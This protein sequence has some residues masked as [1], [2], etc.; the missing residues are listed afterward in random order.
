VLSF[1]AFP[2]YRAALGVEFFLPNVNALMLMH[3]HYVNWDLD[4]RSKRALDGVILDP[5]ILQKLESPNSGIGVP[6]VL[7]MVERLIN[8][9]LSR[10]ET[11]GK[12]GRASWIVRTQSWEV[13]GRQL[14]LSLS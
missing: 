4:D 10:Q 7:E 11:I 6:D 13:I 5:K 9:G 8:T 14:Q 2:L 1:L 12:I 3:A